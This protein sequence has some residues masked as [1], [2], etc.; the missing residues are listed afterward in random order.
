LAAGHDDAADGV[1][2]LE[3]V[4]GRGDLAEDA[5]G[6]RIEHLRPV[7][8]DDADRAFALDDDVFERAHAPPTRLIGRAMCPLA[9]WASRGLKSCRNKAAR[10]AQQ[11]ARP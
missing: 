5:E 9:R 2:G 4:D 11:T 10:N 6:E 8:L 3:I 7:Q 1:I